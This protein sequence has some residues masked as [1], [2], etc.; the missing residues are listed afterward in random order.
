MMSIESTATPAGRA[1]D[2]YRL[3][4]VSRRA[5]VRVRRAG[6]TGPACPLAMA[7]RVRTGGSPRPARS[8]H[9]DVLQ[10]LLGRVVGVC[11]HE[12]PGQ[13]G[14]V[15]APG[16]VIEF[17]DPCPS[18]RT[19]RRA[20]RIRMRSTGVLSSSRGVAFSTAREIHRRQ[21]ARSEWNRRISTLVA[22]PIPCP[23][24]TFGQVTLHRASARG[25]PI[26]SP[27]VAKVWI[28]THLRP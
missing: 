4:A 26:G 9:G 21:P 18:S 17:P 11:R 14:E 6:G 28:L 3:S 2:A 16:L 5:R 8:E 27:R 12:I 15:P 22:G 10:R 25:K 19:K 7:C 1:V 24:R 20:I 13:P 23:R